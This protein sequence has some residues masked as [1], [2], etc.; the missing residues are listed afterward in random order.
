MLLLTTDVNASPF[1]QHLG[2]TWLLQP[3]KTY[4]A[5]IT[6]TQLPLYFSLGF[7]SNEHYFVLGECFSLHMAVELQLIQRSFQ[8]SNL[9]ILFLMTDTVNGSPTAGSWC[10]LKEGGRLW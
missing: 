6:P 5:S 4:Y 8:W 9:T 3:G 1:I 7:C 10:M 2:N